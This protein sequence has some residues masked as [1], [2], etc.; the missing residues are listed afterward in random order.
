M[1]TKQI[2]N[3]QHAL[4]QVF[5]CGGERYRITA[6]RYVEYAQAPTHDGWEYQITRGHWAVGW[7]KAEVIDDMAS[8]GSI[9]RRFHEQR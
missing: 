1:A 7:V 5:F 2:E 8:A 6:R 9:L 3:A 4:G